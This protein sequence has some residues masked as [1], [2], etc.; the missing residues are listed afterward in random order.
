MAIDQDMFNELRRLTEY[1][2]RKNVKRRKK[3]LLEDCILT[4]T[5]NRIVV[6]KQYCFPENFNWTAAK[7]KDIAEIVTVQEGLLRL[8]LDAVKESAA[9]LKID[10]RIGAEMEYHNSPDLRHWLG[11]RGKA[12][13]WHGEIKRIYQNGRQES[14]LTEQKLPKCSLPKI[15]KSSGY[16]KVY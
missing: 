2:L 8:V 9:Q 16:Q 5:K 15:G 11:N 14:I 7:C 3:E 10:A 1:T 4:A 12:V 13:A 6:S